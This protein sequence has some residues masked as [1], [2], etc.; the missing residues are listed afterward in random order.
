MPLHTRDPVGIAGPLDT[1]DGSVGSTGANAQIPARLLNRLMMGAVDDCLGAS[2]KCGKATSRFEHGG[3]SGIVFW[4]GRALRHEVPF[5]MGRGGASF[6]LEIL[7]Q[8]S[9]QIDI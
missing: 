9:S 2:S 3:V 4:F 1:F 5:L 8:C 7:N 6:F